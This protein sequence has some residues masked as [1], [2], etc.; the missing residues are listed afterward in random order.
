VPLPIKGFDVQD[1]TVTAV[2]DSTV[3]VPASAADLFDPAALHWLTTDLPDAGAPAR[4]ALALGVR[5]TVS[6]GRSAT[7]IPVSSGP[8]TCLVRRDESGQV[9]RQRLYIDLGQD[10]LARL[11]TYDQARGDL[12]DVD[13]ARFVLGVPPALWPRLS[14]TMRD[15]LDAGRIRALFPQGYDLRRGQASVFDTVTEADNVF[16]L[17]SWLAGS[18]AVLFRFGAAVS[19]DSAELL[20]LQAGETVTLYA[21]VGFRRPDGDGLTWYRLNPGFLLERLRDQADPLAPYQA[22]AGGTLARVASGAEQTDREELMAVAGGSLG[23]IVLQ[24]AG[25]VPAPLF[26]FT[27]SDRIAVFASSLLDTVPLYALRAQPTLSM[28]GLRAFWNRYRFPAETFAPDAVEEFQATAYHAQMAPKVGGKDQQP[29]R[30]QRWYD[31]LPEVLRYGRYG[32]LIGILGTQS[33]LIAGQDVIRRFVPGGQ[34]NRPDHPD[35]APERRMQLRRL[36]PLRYYFRPGADPAD[37]P[38]FGITQDAVDCIRQEYAFHMNWRPTGVGTYYYQAQRS[39]DPQLLPAGKDEVTTDPQGQPLPAI[40]SSSGRVAVPT[41]AA[42][43]RLEPVAPEFDE[44]DLVQASLSVYQPYTMISSEW[45]D[46]LLEVR[47]LVLTN[48]QELSRVIQA[49]Q[50]GQPDPVP[51]AA[52]SSFL[53]LVVRFFLDLRGSAPAPTTTAGGFLRALL[54]PSVPNPQPPA[55]DVFQRFA[56]DVAKLGAPGAEDPARTVRASSV[57]RPPEHN[58]TVSITIASNHQV[59]L[60]LDLQPSNSARDRRSPLFIAALHD[61]AQRA[62]NRNPRLLGEALLELS[63]GN[64]LFGGFDLTRGGAGVAER[65]QGGK[66]VFKEVLASGALQDLPDQSFANLSGRGEPS[67]L[68]GE[69]FLRTLG[70]V[71][72]TSTPWPQQPLPTFLQLYAFALW[73]ASHVHFTFKPGTPIQLP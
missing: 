49:A 45:T 59:G 47:G 68:V 42:V 54:T 1:P 9:T 26:S 71:N 23:S 11:R 32:S 28:T 61:V 5:Y 44:R 8:M 37:A 16:Q 57:W 43:R 73:E 14:Q 19:L 2:N 48:V 52:L 35:W 67:Q 15:H 40:V 30:S 33:A 13:A 63:A 50:P 21:E 72:G 38:E 62:F 10:D 60:A 29:A 55:I 53:K 27:T 41:R 24:P 64:F 12:F 51:G 3:F 66:T 20:T 25:L 4:D 22:L 18:S 39:A 17:Q 46:R 58:E 31:A 70:E 36:Y 6:P 69:H 34:D 65:V 7:L 56:E